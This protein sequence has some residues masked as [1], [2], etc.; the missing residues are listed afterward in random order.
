[1]GAP[2]AV[3]RG[4]AR[5]SNAARRED[6]RFEAG[7]YGTA[8]AAA[9]ECPTQKRRWYTAIGGWRASGAQMGAWT[10]RFQIGTATIYMLRLRSTFLDLLN[11]FPLM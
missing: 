7:I 2:A 6:A 5:G 9:C 8:L 1:M 11:P 4:E 10:G 3:G